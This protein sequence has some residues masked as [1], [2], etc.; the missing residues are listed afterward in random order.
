MDEKTGTYLLE[1]RR[2]YKPPP[3]PSCGSKNVAVSWVNAT[4]AADP[5]GRERYIP[6]AHRCRSCG[7]LAT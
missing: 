4:S 6:G 7:G 1:E 3:C 5:P 2:E